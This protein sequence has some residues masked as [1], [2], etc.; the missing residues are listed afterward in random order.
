VARTLRSVPLLGSRRPCRHRASSFRTLL[1]SPAGVPSR[2]WSRARSR[3]TTPRC[4]ALDLRAFFH[5]GVRCVRGTLPSRDRSMLP[6]ALDRLVSRRCR[7]Y[8]A[9]QLALDIPPGGPNRFGVPSPEREGKAGCFGPVWLL[10]IGIEHPRR[11]GR[12]RSRWLRRVSRRS[13]LGRIPNGPRRGCQWICPEERSTASARTPEGVGSDVIAYASPKRLVRDPAL[14]P[15][16]GGRWFELL[17]SVLPRLPAYMMERPLAAD[18]HARRRV[19]LRVTRAHP[20]LRR[21]EMLRRTRL[22]N[23]EG[24]ERRASRRRHP[25]V[26]PWRLVTPTVSSKLEVPAQGQT[27]VVFTRTAETRSEDEVSPPIRRSE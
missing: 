3:V 11:D 8:R 17:P 19:H 20:P 25:E 12:A 1:R 10:A 4:S 27:V 24:L 15:K 6:W 2:R 21:R 26:G 5:R 7:A 23:P 16:S 9:A 13:R 22:P 18:T 14:A